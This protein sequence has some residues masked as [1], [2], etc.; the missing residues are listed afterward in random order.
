[1]EAPHTPEGQVIS[2]I[3]KSDSKLLAQLA[4]Y[5]QEWPLKPPEQY[6]G[7][8]PPTKEASKTTADS[9][10]AKFWEWRTISTDIK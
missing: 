10:D 9:E 2:S 3:T 1:M 4:G 5:S 6:F 8:P 7:E